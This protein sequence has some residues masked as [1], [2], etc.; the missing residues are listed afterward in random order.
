[1]T[2]SSSGDCKIRL[3]RVLAGAGVASR[4]KAESLISQGKV[5][6]N[7][8]IVT[9][10][11]TRIDPACDVICVDG[12]RI[13]LETKIYLM[14][15]KPPG[16]LSS[17]SDDRGRPT[18]VDLLK[19][20]TQ[21]VFPVGR[22][23]YDT[24]GLLLMSNDGDFANLMTHP[25]YEMPREYEAWCRGLITDDAVRQL[26]KGVLLEEGMT[27]PARARIL[28]QSQSKSKVGIEIRE[29]HKRQ[30]KRM[31]TAVGFPVIELKRIRLGSL[32]LGELPEGQFR[33][34]SADEVRR[35]RKEAGQASNP[36]G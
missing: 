16:Y 30:V 12:R 11:G 24:R 31:L 25:R 13:N 4:R 19:G 10:M 35:L 22:L 27:S 2:K 26:E 29:G 33:A 20:V 5:T 17:V 14:L 9:E 7:D 1:M 28:Y 34:L 36:E 23:D 6:V 3:S 21:R 18:V 8:Q 32:V 15:N